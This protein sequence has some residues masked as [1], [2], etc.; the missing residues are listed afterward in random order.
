MLFRPK[1]DTMI[2]RKMNN[3]KNTRA[4]VLT[5]PLYHGDICIMHGTDIHKYYEVRFSPGSVITNLC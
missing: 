3:K 1:R 4:P 5:F 2:G